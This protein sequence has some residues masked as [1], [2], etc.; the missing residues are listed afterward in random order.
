MHR[1]DGEG[2]TQDN[3]FT[4]GNPS[5]GTIATVVTADWANAVQEEIIA[6]LEAAGIEPSK[7]NS[8][9]LV[10]AI[11]SLISG[12]GTA[13]SAAGVS[14]EDPNEYFSGENVEAAL[15]QLAEKIYAGT[16][17]AIQVRRSTTFITAT[18]STA[19]SL[20]AENFVLIFNSGS[21]VYTLPP[22][23]ELNLPT[24]TSIHIVQTGTGKVTIQAGAG[25]SLRYPP[26]F[27][28]RTMEQDATI[29]AMKTGSNS[30]RLGG[31]L[32]AAS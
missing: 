9:Q 26:S 11:Q 23:S 29:V 12:G 8:A 13:V 1:I 32:E 18:N 22:D 2:A 3:R 21:P 10:A 30:W 25:V 15:N 17:N 27:N 4:E 19:E 16:I 20:H 6:V 31:M 5:T 28:P 7:S 24:G 14:I